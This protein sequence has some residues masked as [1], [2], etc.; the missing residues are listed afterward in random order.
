MDLLQEFEQEVD[1]QK[2]DREDAD[3]KKN[4][5]IMRLEE[6]IVLVKKQSKRALR[7]L[8]QDMQ[9][10]VNNL[11]IT[12]LKQYSIESTIDADDSESETEAPKM[13]TALTKDKSPNFRAILNE[14]RV[15]VE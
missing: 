5:T 13:K 1:K 2:R 3:R 4:Q 12:Y 10:Q 14:K 6:Q 15:I 7:A 9:G 8:K 11:K